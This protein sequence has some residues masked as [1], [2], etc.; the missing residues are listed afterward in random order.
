[1]LMLKSNGS[2]YDYVIRYDDHLP[3]WNMNN[4]DKYF[5]ADINGDGKEDLYVFNT[6]D[7]ATQWLGTAISS[8]T[9]LSVATKQGDWIGGWNLGGVDKIAV[10]R[11]ATGRDHLFIYNTNWFGYLWSGSSGLYQKL[12]ITATSMHLNTTIMDGT[13]KIPECYV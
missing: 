2:S 5:V 3:N 6:S 10:D 4:N 7:W 1:M 9:G 12:C 11:R 13:N 8:G